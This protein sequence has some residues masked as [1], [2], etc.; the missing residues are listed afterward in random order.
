VLLDIQEMLDSPGLSGEDELSLAMAL[1]FAGDG[2]KAKTIAE[3]L[4]SEFTE[5][6]GNEIRAKIGAGDDAAQTKATARLALLASA[7]DLPQAG[8]LVQ[9][10]MNNTY[11]GDYYLLEKMGIAQNRLETLPEGDAK[12]TYSL[13]GATKTIDLH[14]QAAYSLTLLPEQLSEIRF[15]NVSG[16]IT[17]LSCYMKEGR[18]PDGAAAL[19]QLTLKRSVNGSGDSAVTVPQ[20][21]PVRISLEFSIAKDA[22][23]GCYTITDMLPAGLRF[24]NVEGYYYYAQVGG[25]ENKE[26]KFSIYKTDYS[27]YKGWQPAYYQKDGSLKGT[28][29]YTAYPAMTG[30]FTAEAPYFGH[31][32]DDNIL[33]HAPETRITIQ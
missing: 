22:P 21:K 23:N 13:G 8:G 30:S 4:V 29:T 28:I 19:G 32:I 10:M 17:M 18:A 2:A 26:V 3:G 6:L 27:R 33:I 11:D 9:Y 20:N 5:D 31:S 15:S 12:F 7:F 1:Y 16:D 14:E 24:G 25:N